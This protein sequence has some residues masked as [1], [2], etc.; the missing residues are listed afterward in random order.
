MEAQYDFDAGSAYFGIDDIN[1]G[2]V[3]QKNLK[4]FFIKCG[5]SSSKK[6]LIACIRR[7]DLDADAKLKKEEFIEGLK[8][9]NVYSKRKFKDITNKTELKQSVLS[10]DGFSS[11]KKSSRKSASKF[12][13]QQSAVF[14][15][16][17]KRTSQRSEITSAGKTKRTKSKSTVMRESKEKS[18]NDSPVRR[19]LH[20]PGRYFREN[21]DGIAS[22]R[23]ERK[24][25]YATVD[26][27]PGQS[28]MS[29]MKQSQTRGYE[30]SPYNSGAD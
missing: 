5:F 8:A 2:Y 22:T 11:K 3:D 21:P 19:T 9:Q 18:R 4:R 10:S 16:K 17:S 28:Q 26:Y 24:K 23:A 30:Y 25:D 15:A 6:L 20:S 12:S 13:R 29:Q 1:Y 14:S 27:A 7:I